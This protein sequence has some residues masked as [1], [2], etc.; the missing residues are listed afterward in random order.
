MATNITYMYARHILILRKFLIVKIWFLWRDDH[1]YR[2]RSI[3]E[4]IKYSVSH[5]GVVGFLKAMFNPM[6]GL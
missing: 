1:G 6:E 2:R 4:E 5:F 3:H